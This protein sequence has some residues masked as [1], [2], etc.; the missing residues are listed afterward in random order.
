MKMKTAPKVMLIAGVV[1]GGYFG[2]TA[3][4]MMIKES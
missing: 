4:M 2:I 3:L 1:I